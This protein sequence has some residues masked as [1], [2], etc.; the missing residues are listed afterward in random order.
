MEPIVIAFANASHVWLDGHEP[1][2]SRSQYA[3]QR[4]VPSLTHS[5]PA[6]HSRLD[7]HVCPFDF[8]PIKRVEG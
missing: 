2:W 8:V 7:A 1:D 4:A 6:W 3:R 5:E